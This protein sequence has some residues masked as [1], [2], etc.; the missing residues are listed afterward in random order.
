MGNT[1]C[2]KD[3]YHVHEDGSKMKKKSKKSKKKSN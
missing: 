3:Q 2:C 1:A